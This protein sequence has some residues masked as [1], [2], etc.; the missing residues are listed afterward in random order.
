MKRLLALL[1]TLVLLL[2]VLVMPASAESA[3]ST[4]DLYCTV[5]T[6]G[7][8]LVTMQVSLRLENSYQSLS[9]P[10]PPTAKSITLN[11]SNVS[12]TRTDSAVLVDISRIT[13]DYLGE[14][15]LRFEY[16]LP[17]AVRVNKESV[18]EKLKNG[19]ELTD[20]L[21][22][23]IPM[24]CGFELPV[25]SLKFT[26]TMP[27]GAMTNQPTFTSTYR[28]ASVESDLNILITDNQ[29]IGSS[30]TGMNDRDG[31]TMT[32]VVPESMFPTV[33][34]YVRNGNPE[35]VPIA[36]FA[37]L[38]LLYWLLRLRTLPIHR[39]D[40]TTS[41]EGV[42]AG[43]LGCRLTLCGGDLTMM[44]FTWA[45]LG[46]LIISMDENGKVLL[47]KRMDMGNERGPFENKIFRLL[48][49]SRRV[50]D[51]TG[52]TYAKLCLKTA[53]QVPQ[54]KNMYKG[55][56]GNIKIFRALACVCQIFA[57]ICVAMNLSE[58]LWLATIMAVILGVVGAVTGWLIQDMAYRTHLRGK[59]PVLLGLVSILLWT[60]L[61]LLSGQVWIPLGVSLGQWVY[62]Y[63]AAYGGRRS[64]LGRHDAG[65]VLGLR[66]H[67]KHVPKASVNR[68]LMN[69][70]DYFFNYAP[71][72]IALGV[73]GPFGRAFGGR[74][75]DQCPYLV[76][77]ITGR[78]TAEEWGH[79]LQDTADIMDTKSR[80]MQIERWIPLQV[81]FKIP[82]KK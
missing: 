43:E 71:Y 69:D 60:V 10:L 18:L 30:K 80:R 35:L 55:S 6:D 8:C 19:E 72:A 12:S 62:G 53:R 47:H 2:C 49:G 65:Q 34:T 74:K 67:L 17:E 3:A 64:D 11:G 27:N 48:F 7:D 82:K 79:L 75:L 36:V 13:K 24:L 44:V 59:V 21:I 15:I 57:G 26:V 56:S 31:M 45:Q 4:V 33:S 16:T 22:L 54:Q 9:F 28:Q 38:A 81:S 76:T 29:I 40:A 50:V 51:A 63:F 39:V 52:D 32:M 73:M 23:E 58:T 25:E 37:V 77:N 41:P 20:R 61:G 42:T 5:N 68:L 78:R 70:P 1:F 14:A 46:Y 66:Q